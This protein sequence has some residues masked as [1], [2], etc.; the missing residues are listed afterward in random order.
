M[1]PVQIYQENGKLW[2][3]KS[4]SLDMIIENKDHK[5]AV[6]KAVYKYWKELRKGIEKN[7]RKIFNE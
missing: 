2:N 7:R 4:I 5:I 6:S 1:P 3:E